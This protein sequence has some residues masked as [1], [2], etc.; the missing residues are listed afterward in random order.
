M[1]RTH[2]KKVIFKW[3]ILVCIGICKGS[4][5][6][7]IWCEIEFISQ[8]LIPIFFVGILLIQTHIAQRSNWEILLNWCLLMLVIV[9]RSTQFNTHYLFALFC[10]FNW[11]I[12]VWL[13][14]CLF[15]VFLRSWT[16]N[17]LCMD[18]RNRS[19]YYALIAN[20]TLFINYIYALNSC[21]LGIITIIFTDFGMVIIFLWSIIW[22]Q[23]QLLPSYFFLLYC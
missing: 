12:S 10:L 18:W 9:S 19:T 8:I 14:F 5:I 22:N 21:V 15:E 17:W 13:L 20:R 16:V 4:L 1:I 7:S 11:C 3:I 23:C 6:L 2:H